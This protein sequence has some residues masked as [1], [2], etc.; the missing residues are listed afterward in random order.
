MMVLLAQLWAAV[1]V[2]PGIATCLAIALLAGLANYP[3]WERRL[4]V[5]GQHELIRQQGETMLAALTDRSRINADLAALTEAQEVID[6][7]LVSEQSM[8]VN[9][10]YFYRLEKLNRVRLS[11]ID[12]LGATP[13]DRDSPFRTIPVSLQVSG[14]YRN[15][16]AF[17]RELET[18]PRIMRTSSY[19]LERADPSGGEL[20]LYLTVELLAHP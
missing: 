14:T 1:R 4:V 13:A 12:Q 6:R 10:G 7:N 16:L 3:L 20:A 5:T 18:G 11:R 17:V 9:L 8:E 2:R 19:R 15:L